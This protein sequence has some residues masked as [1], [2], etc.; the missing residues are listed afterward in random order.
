MRLTFWTRWWKAKRT[1]ST[2]EYWKL[3]VS[4]SSDGGRGMYSWTGRKGGKERR[5]GQEGGRKGERGRGGR[6]E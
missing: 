3:G 6:K 1:H 5:E 4:P 2:V